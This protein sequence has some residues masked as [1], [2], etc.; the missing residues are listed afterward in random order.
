MACLEFNGVGRFLRKTVSCPQLSLLPI[1]G[2]P[3][4]VMWFSAFVY[5]WRLEFNSLLKHCVGTNCNLITPGYLT[6]LAL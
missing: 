6:F 1:P 5:K 3:G 2:S 4:E